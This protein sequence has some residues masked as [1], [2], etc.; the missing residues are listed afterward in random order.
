VTTSTDAIESRLR[1]VLSTSDPAPVLTSADLDALIAL[2]D[3]ANAVI[4]AAKHRR[5]VRLDSLDRAEYLDASAALD[6][7][8]DRLVS[9]EAAVRPLCRHESEFQPSAG[10]RTPT[11]H[12]TAQAVSARK[13][14]TMGSARQFPLG[15]VLSVAT[16]ILLADDFGQ[17]HELLDH[18]TGDTLFT[19]QI[20]RAAGECADEV[21]RQHPQLRE[22]AVPEFA[23]PTKATVPAWVAEQVA[24]FGTSLPVA[25]L[26]AGDHTRI[27]PLTEMAMS[28]P[29]VEVI[30]VVIEG[31][32]AGVDPD[33]DA[34]TVHDYLST[35]CLHGRHGYCSARSGHVGPKEP[36]TCKFCPAKCRCTCHANGPGDPS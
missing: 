12:G 35:G 29:H 15:A 6:V 19:H 10:V 5:R 31:R 17:V 24:R 26:A 33:A 32:D 1:D 13:D 34:A 2:H 27:D 30:P 22:V 8:V 9:L 16:G 11:R 21:Y 18:M 36:A 23:E 20:P 4:A 3:A 7:A 28:Y 14:G 25:P